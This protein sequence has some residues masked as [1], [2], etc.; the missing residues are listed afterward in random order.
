[1]KNWQAAAKNWMLRSKKFQSE[2]NQRLVPHQLNVKQ[3]N[4]EE[5]L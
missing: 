1:M 4:Y 3:T 2:K 5:R